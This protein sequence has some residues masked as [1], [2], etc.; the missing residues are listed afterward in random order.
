MTERRRTERALQKLLEQRET[1][2]AEMS[3]RIA[4][5]LQI[6]TSILL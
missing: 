4:N 6:I 2:L 1:L 5:S 3:N